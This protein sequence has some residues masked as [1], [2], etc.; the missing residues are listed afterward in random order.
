MTRPILISFVVAFLGAIALPVQGNFPGAFFFNV[1]DKYRDWNHDPLVHADGRYDKAHR[2]FRLFAGA[3]PTSEMYPYPDKKFVMTKKRW[4]KSANEAINGDPDWFDVEVVRQRAE[5]EEY[6]P[7]IELLGWMYEKGRGLNKDLRKAYNL[8]ERAKLVGEAKVRGDT[9]KIYDSLT[10]PEKLVADIV[11]Q[12][13]IRR[14]KPNSALTE[15]G[16]KRVKLH[17]MKKQRELNSR[18]NKLRNAKKRSKGLLDF[19]R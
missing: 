17:V 3:H 15:K 7:A 19:A 18:R 6:A 16:P 10:Q 11:L 4:L 12:E 5:V 2:G 9:E 13:D 1:S 8:Y 14:I